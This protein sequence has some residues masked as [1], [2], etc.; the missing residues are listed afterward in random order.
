M[1]ESPPELQ[2]EIEKLELKH[3]QHPEGR[4]FVPLANAYRKVGE[5][6]HA[7]ALLREGLRQHPDY[8]SAHIVLGRCL[9]DRGAMEEA[10]EEFRFVL[11][12][13]PQNLIALR[14]LGELSVS[15]GRAAEAIGWYEQLLSVDPMN[16]EARRALDSMP[17]EQAEDLDAEFRPGGGWWEPPAEEEADAAPPASGS[18]LDDDEEDLPILRG[19]EPASP[20]QARDPAFGQDFGFDRDDVDLTAP[21]FEEDEVSLEPPLPSAAGEV[22][23]ETIAELYA[24]Q[25]LHDRAAGVYRELVRRRGGDPAL[26][27]RLAELEA[28]ASGAGAAEPLPSATL[29]AEPAAPAAGP[30]AEPL[31]PL[32]E[33]PAESLVEEPAIGRDDL[34]PGDDEWLPSLDAT[35]IQPES[36]GELPLTDHDPFAGSFETG[37]DA[38]EDLSSESPAEPV[39]EPLAP[40]EPPSTGPTISAYLDALIGWRPGAQAPAAT[41]TAPVAEM[42]PAEAW[43]P[44][45]APATPGPA[46]VEA[47][48]EAA[49]PEHAAPLPELA[50]GA[51]MAD[52]PFPWEAASTP[53]EVPEES[54]ARDDL[55]SFDSFLGESPRDE[56]SSA[57]PAPRPVEPTAAAPAAADPAPLAGTA[58][59]AEEEDDLESFQAWLRSLKR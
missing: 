11:T 55:F 7:E 39:V 27:R 21:M 25:G 45:A 40:A 24:R 37:F 48:P 4:F 18:I 3:T 59:A 32:G 28:L 16:E 17:K 30:D 49:R 8:L 41:G 33:P 14:T 29:P 42:T 12:L 23:T 1:A 54:G 43:A 51:G 47:E 38:S 52:E 20:G 58:A 15:A 5:V 44:E 13:D 35:A 34:A 10:S 50:A 53:L 26:E 9:A 2:H 56:L 36:A 19:I 46:V 31:V 22:V 6:D 57:E